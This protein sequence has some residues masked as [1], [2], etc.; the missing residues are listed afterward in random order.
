[1]MVYSYLS[2][3]DL[4][5]L[6]MG[7]SKRERETVIKWANLLNKNLRLFIRINLYKHRVK[8]VISFKQVTGD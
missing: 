3:E 5:E 8:K 1:M 4:V 6:L 7:L 2:F